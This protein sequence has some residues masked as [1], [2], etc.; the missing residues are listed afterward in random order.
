M[1]II[2]IQHNHD[3]YH[4]CFVKRV[5]V[6]ERLVIIFVVKTNGKMKE[7]HFWMTFITQLVYWQKWNGICVQQ[8]QF[9]ILCFYNTLFLW[10][11][12]QSSLL[13]LVLK[14]E[15]NVSKITRR[16]SE[17]GIHVI[18]YTRGRVSKFLRTPLLHNWHVWVSHHHLLQF[19]I[20]PHFLLFARQEL[21]MITY[22]RAECKS[23]K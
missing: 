23:Q 18:F 19:V 10:M 5:F 7:V 4:R 2:Y 15:M 12:R 13:L 3:R 1:H 22:F 6:V 8:Q 17:K 20:F 9:M 11:G 16:H 21:F 14:A